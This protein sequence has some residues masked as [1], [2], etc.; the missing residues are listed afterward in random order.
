[1]KIEGKIQY[2]NQDFLNILSESNFEKTLQSIKVALEDCEDEV[3]E[4]VIDLEKENEIK[5]KRRMD[6]LNGKLSNLINA[7]SEYEKVSRMRR[8]QLY[9]DTMHQQSAS[10]AFSEEDQNASTSTRGTAKVATPLLPKETLKPNQKSS[11]S[12]ISSSS[13]QSTI[14]GI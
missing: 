7:V 3:V 9:I 2:Y 14:Q 1:M 13:L 12:H 5:H 6:D 11:L 8:T 4:L 10:Q